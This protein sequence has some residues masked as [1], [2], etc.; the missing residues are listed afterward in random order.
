MKWERLGELQYIIPIANLGSILQMGILSAGLA[1]TVNHVRL[2]G[3]GTKEKRKKRVPGGMALDSYAGLYF[4]ARNPVMYRLRER[5]KE[6]CVVKVNRQVMELPDVVV[7]DRDALV[8]G[9]RFGHGI[10]GLNL[11]DEEQVYARDWTHVDKE[12][13]RDLKQVKC[14]EVLVPGTV[15]P[16]FLQGVYFSCASSAYFEMVNQLQCIIDPD[17]F[18]LS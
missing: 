3:S 7:A 8:R 18:F 16:R 1:E 10:P 14:A 9:A 17:I 12:I 5:H 15:R 13:Q 11:I 4:C 6:L 2:I